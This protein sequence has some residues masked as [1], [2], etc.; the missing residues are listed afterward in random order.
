MRPQQLHG[1]P[2]LARTPWLADWGALVAAAE[3]SAFDLAA[4]LAG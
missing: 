1:S 4:D 3:G 2:F